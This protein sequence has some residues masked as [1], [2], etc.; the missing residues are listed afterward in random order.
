MSIKSIWNNILTFL[1]LIKADG[2]KALTAA[3]KVVNAILAFEQTP[4]GQEIEH[5]AEQFLPSELKAAFTLWLP[6]FLKALKWA[7]D[8]L[9]K[10]DAAILAD[11]LTYFKATEGDLK[12]LQANT[13][14]AGI[15]KFT[16]DNTGAGLTIQHSI[17]AAQS[18]HNPELV[19]LV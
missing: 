2:E 9:N 6:Q 14:A 13:L 18:V 4:T 17:I 3:N 5:V 10:S 11:G 16:S 15:S 19:N 7:S 1:H 8:E 12:A